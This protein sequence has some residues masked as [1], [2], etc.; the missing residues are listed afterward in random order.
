MTSNIPNPLCVV[1]VAKHLDDVPGH[2]DAHGHGACISDEHLGGLTKDI[3]DEEGNQGSCKHEGEHGIGIVMSFVHGDAEHQAESDAKAAGKAIDTINHIHGVDDADT[4]EDGEGYTYP[5]REVLDAPKA[6]QA[7][8]AGTIAEDDAKHSK[9]FDDEAIARDEIN[10]IVDGTHIEHHAHSKDDG[11]DGIAVAEA[12]S[13]QGA[14][15]ESEEHSNASHDGHRALLEFAGIGIIDEVLLLGDGE[16]LEIDPERHQ[17][18]DE[19][20]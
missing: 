5:P 2:Q 15:N 19:G 11:Q 16:D 7:V 10:D 12:S 9:D 3:M 8:D 1:I 18:G 20:R 4:C 13:K 14:T 17:H 6:M